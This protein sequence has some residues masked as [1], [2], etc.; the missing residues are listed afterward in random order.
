VVE[1]GIKLAGIVEAG[2]LALGF[3]HVLLRENGS[4]D[5]VPSL[6]QLPP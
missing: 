5:F 6:A 3:F 2:A 1:H 4:N